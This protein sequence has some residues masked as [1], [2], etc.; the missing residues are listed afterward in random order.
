MPYTYVR[1]VVR[2][3]VSMTFTGPLIMEEI[4]ASMGRQV[5]DGCWAHAVLCDARALHGAAETAEVRVLVDYQQSLS[6]VHGRRGPVAVVTNEPAQ[7]GMGRMFGALI[8]TPGGS[9]FGVFTS[10]E[11][12]DRWLDEQQSR[13]GE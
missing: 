12:A 10:I 11:A 6:R 4:M 9:P 2:R 8:D 1:D 5:A 7:F 3:R 13:L